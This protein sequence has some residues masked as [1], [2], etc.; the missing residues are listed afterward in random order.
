MRCCAAATECSHERYAE[1]W[2]ILDHRLTIFMHF[3]QI[4]MPIL[5]TPE[6]HNYVTEPTI[7]Y[8]LLYQLITP[9][10]E[11][12]HDFHQPIHYNTASPNNIQFYQQ[13]IFLTNQFQFSTTNFNFQQIII[14]SKVFVVPKVATSLRTSVFKFLHASQPLATI[15]IDQL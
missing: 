12:E 6:K 7:L 10:T 3:L 11:T 8:C 2:N 14:E 5:A 13:K 15:I 9:V 4:Y 1:D